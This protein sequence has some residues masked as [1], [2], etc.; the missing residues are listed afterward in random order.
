MSDS[1]DQPTADRHPITLQEMGHRGGSTT[2]RRHGSAFYSRIG[3]L[4]ALK[5][6]GKV[7]PIPEGR[8]D[9]RGGHKKKGWAPPEGA[10]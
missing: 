8:S 9:N 5:R 6:N 3:K 1:Q 4:G 10:E 2:Y 7:K